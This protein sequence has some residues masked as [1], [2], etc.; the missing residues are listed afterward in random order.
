MGIKCCPPSH[1]RSSHEQL[2]PLSNRHTFAKARHIPCS[3]VIVCLVFAELPRAHEYRRFRK[4]DVYG[5]YEVAMNCQKCNS[6]IDYRFLTNCAQC[7]CAVEPASA[8]LNP[9]LSTPTT[10]RKRL[11]WVR[12]LINAAYVLTI[13]MF[14]TISGVITFAVATMFLGMIER[15][16]Y[17]PNPN[18]S[19]CGRGEL[20]SI[21]MLLSG[22]FL[23][24]VGAAVFAVSRPIFRP[25]N[26]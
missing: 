4:S 3:I 1:N 25:Q 22:A 23:G 6:E 2:H 14:G 20:I 21:L 19:G 18:V 8:E 9:N 11:G 24:T 17:P 12:R 26:R 5:S 16:I 7:G 15:A 10:L 13:S